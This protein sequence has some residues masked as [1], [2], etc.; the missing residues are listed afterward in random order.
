MSTHR[1]GRTG[2]EK[3]VK[4]EYFDFQLL[5]K[6]YF[7]EGEPAERDYPGC[8][9]DFEI[10]TVDLTKGSALELINQALNY[11]ELICKCIELIES[12]L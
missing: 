10:E 5:V 6:G 12:D 1:S 4:V 3:Y 11:D 2:I 7:I 9:H 8:P